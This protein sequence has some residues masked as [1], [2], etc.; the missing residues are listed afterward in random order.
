MSYKFIIIP[1]VVW[2]LSQTIKFITRR[3][4]NQRDR[5]DKPAWVYQWAGG[6]PSTH[7][8]MLTSGLYLIAKYS[9]IGPLFGFG[10]T[11]SLL[12][13]YN[14]L[15]DRK[16]ENI[17]EGRWRIADKKIFKKIFGDQAL[18]DINGHTFMEIVIGVVFGAVCGMVLDWWL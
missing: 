11:V 9:G 18:L 16:K 15:E 8:A 13:M 17:E 14:L 7:S 2:V 5:L 6:W 3:F 10:M 4:Q 1:L 12:F